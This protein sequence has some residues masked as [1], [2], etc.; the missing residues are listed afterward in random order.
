MEGCHQHCAPGDRVHSKIQYVLQ[1]VSMI[2]LQ[3]TIAGCK[4]CL[5]IALRNFKNTRIGEASDFWNRY[6]QDIQLAKDIG[7]H[8]CWLLGH[9]SLLAGIV[10]GLYQYSRLGRSHLLR[11]VAL[12]AQQF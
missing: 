4:C 2:S 3:L 5:A 7:N 10:A 9:V 6:E 8:T 11:L 12:V 1:Y